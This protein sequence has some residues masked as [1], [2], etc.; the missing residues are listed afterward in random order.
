MN[1]SSMQKVILLLVLMAAVIGYYSYQRSGKTESPKPITEYGEETIRLPKSIPAPRETP[2]PEPTQEPGTL[3]KI[4]GAAIPE[5]V[6]RPTQDPR[7]L[8]RS[9]RTDRYGNAC[10]LGSTD[11]R[12][13]RR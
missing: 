2:S 1:S 13:A 10:Q 7:L 12:C 5:T 3:E 8:D 11:P 9:I 6:T 4:F